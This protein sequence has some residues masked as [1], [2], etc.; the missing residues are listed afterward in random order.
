MVCKG[1]RMEI[2][3]CHKVRPIYTIFAH[4]PQTSGDVRKNG[5]SFE[6]DFKFILPLFKT[7]GHIAAR[8]KRIPAFVARFLCVFGIQLES[9]FP[10][11]AIFVSQLNVA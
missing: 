8:L 7:A 11:A 10:T 5:I 4:H 3:P 9:S 1:F 2:P 6:P